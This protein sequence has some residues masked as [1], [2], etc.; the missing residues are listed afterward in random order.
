[1]SSDAGN[2]FKQDVADSLESCDI[3]QRTHKVN[4]DV[5]ALA[6]CDRAIAS[7]KKRIDQ[8]VADKAGPWTGRVAEITRATNTQT[9]ST[10]RN[11][12]DDFNKPGHDLK[13]VIA[14]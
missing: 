5:K 7:F 10:I 12:P 6:A 13:L 1:M 4:K 8:S 14:R 2:E 11:K 3:V 9:H